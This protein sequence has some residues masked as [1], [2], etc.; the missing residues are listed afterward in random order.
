[1]KPHETLTGLFNMTGIGCSF[2]FLL[3]VSIEKSIVNA[4][5]ISRLN[6]TSLFALFLLLRRGAFTIE[7]STPTLSRNLN[8]HFIQL[9]LAAFRLIKYEAKVLLSAV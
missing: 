2:K 6:L 5:R 4:P 7:S 8:E 3:K 1:M 9:L